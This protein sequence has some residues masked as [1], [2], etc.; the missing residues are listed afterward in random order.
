MAD[1]SDLKNAGL[2]VTS[3]R[4][5]ILKLLETSQDR[6]LS[7]ESIHQQLKD[8]GEE[9]VLATVYR[10]LAQFEEAGL[11]H[12]HYFENGHSV[13][14]L[15][16]GDHHDHLV[17]VRCQKVEEFCDPVIEA[18]QEKIAQQFDFQIT[19]HSLYLYGVC[20]DCR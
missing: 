9:V 20:R 1:Q 2:K 10:V 12:K 8:Q 13:F 16:S 7:A 17:C 18:H 5:T 15:D 6:H 3:A 14:E 19:D 4:L 11:V